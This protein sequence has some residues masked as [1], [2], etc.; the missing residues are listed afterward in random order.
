MTSRENKE[1]KSAAKGDR[2]KEPSGKSTAGANNGAGSG[3][4][5][6]PP[7]HEPLW[8]GVSGWPAWKLTAVV[9]AACALLYIPF[10]GSYGLWDPWET[11]YGEVSR[12]ILQRQD[13]VSPFWQ[14][15]WFWSKP[16]LTF[17]LQSFGMRVMGVNQ[18]GAPPSEMALSTRPEWGMR[19]PIILVS[20]LCLWALFHAVR[21]LLGRRTALL[22]VVV[23]AT[24][25]LYAFT[26]RQSITDIPFVGPMTAALAFLMLAFFTD[27]KKEAPKLPKLR[28]W[29]LVVAAAAFMVLMF[30]GQDVMS[31]LYVPPVLFGLHLAVSAF[32]VWSFIRFRP[33]GGGGED[34]PRSKKAAGVRAYV[35]VL[36]IE[37]IV[38]VFG[39]AFFGPYTLTWTSIFLLAFA[40]G[41]WELIEGEKKEVTG[42]H[43]LG[44]ALALCTWPQLIYY[45]GFIGDRYDMVL[46]VSE[47]FRINFYGWIYMLP[48]MAMWGFYVVSTRATEHRNARY[49]YVHT[50]WLLS[51]VA[52]LAKGLGGLAIPVAV[53]GLFI[54]LTRRWRLLAELELAR[55]LA[56]WFA[57]AAPWHH[58][59]W[60]RHKKG[61]W[62]EYFG[63]HHFKRA[64]SGVHG[65]RGALDYFI[66]QLGFG[67]FP[68]SALLPAAVVRWAAR[69]TEKSTRGQIQ[70]FLVAWAGLCFALFAIMET[71]FHHYI[72]PAVPPLAILVA[73][74]IDE[75][76]ERTDAG[77]VLGVVASLGL[78]AL[79]GRDL[80]RDPQHL[81]LLFIYKY[82][83][84][85]PYELGFETG[86][87]IITVLAAIPLGLLAF[88]RLRPYAIWG[89]VAAGVVTGFWALDHYM[90]EL[91]PHWSQKQL[92]ATYYRNREGPHERLIAWE[93]NWRGENFYTKN[94]VVVHMQPKEVDKFKAY[95]RRYRGRT[96]YLILEQGRFKKLERVLPT[97]RAKETLEIVGPAG[98]PWPDE[99]E[100]HFRDKRYKV[101]KKPYMSN[102]F[103]LV[104]TT[105]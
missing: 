42:W 82:D 70:I 68:W 34:D 20:I 52:V 24:S 8:G 96:F 43:L 92:H 10:A 93:L 104:R 57:V 7:S 47:S 30:P 40:F 103:L 56:I 80:F 23:C 31:R 11:H 72:L 9:L 44:L 28:F 41:G 94:R 37:A 61:F 75:T 86:I 95:L 36:S 18:L 19:V 85:F 29:M 51:A 67:M 77:V 38:G 73:M 79:M 105:I 62:N 88:R 48:W 99:W 22:A 26:T 71:K 59:M 63:H 101:L 100:R 55:G 32:A 3:V 12:T 4:D 66:Y 46:R 97:Q 50:A 33:G 16:I 81:V 54:L 84:L 74:W 45:G 27:R 83:R 60:V 76:L 14:D 1:N 6:R 69:P 91:S 49:L 39:L 15:K 102:K 17:W 65:Q 53:V 64:Q 89:M 78:L 90:L 98:E 58:A 35:A 2:A 87:V 5:A 21:K 13:P 25:P